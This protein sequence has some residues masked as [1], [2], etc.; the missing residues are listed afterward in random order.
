LAGKGSQG[1]IYP[2]CVWAAKE[3]DFLAAVGSQEI[4]FPWRVMAAKDCD[5][6]GGC[7]IFL[8][9]EILPLF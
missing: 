9:T 1:T 5:L 7:Y 3:C 6:L 2:W 8:A 4:C